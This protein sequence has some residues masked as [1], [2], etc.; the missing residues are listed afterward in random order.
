MKY[1]SICSGIE[2]ATVAWHGFGWTPLAFSE[3]EA[4]PSAVLAARWPQVPNLGDMTKFAEWPEEI[5]AECDLLVGGPP[6][7][8][9][10]VAG[11][12]KSL[13]D[14]RGNITLAYV[15]LLNHI[16]EVRKRHGRPPA[17]ALY[18]NV[19]G[20]LS[21]KDNAF[22]CLIGAL[23]GCDEAPETETGKW[24]KAGYVCGET[25][26]V[27]Y[28]I[29]D[30]QFFGVAQRRRR[31][32]LV[33]V[34]SELVASLGDNACPSEILSLRESVRGN[35][36]SRSKAWEGAARS[37]AASLTSSGRGVER[38]G[39][40]THALTT[41]AACEEDGTGIGNPIVPAHAVGFNWQNGGG[42][43]KANDGLGITEEGTGPL[44]RCNT[45]AVAFTQNQREEVRILDVA[46]ACSAEP[47]SHQQTYIAQQAVAFSDSAAANSHGIAYMVEG[48]PP[49]RG[50]QG[51]NVIPAVAYV[52]ATNLHSKEEAPRYEEAAVSACLNGWDERHDP[53]KH[54]VAVAFKP[55]QSE[56]AGGTFVTEEFAP[57]MQGQNNGSTAVP[58]VAFA[59]R[60]RDG[61]KVP[62]I[63]KDGV[64]P[65]LTNPGGG[66][67]SDAV[68]VCLP[69]PLQEVSK[70]TGKS[71]DDPRAGIG[72]GSAGD[73][74][75]TLQA[76]AQHGCHASMQ[77][78]RLTPAECEFLQGFPAG[79]TDIIF[80]KKPAADGPRYRALGNS[81]A[82]PCMF[83]LGHRIQEATK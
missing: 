15:R 55:G 29:L 57:T 6:C 60:T 44:Q 80:R 19:P 56:A 66:G 47:G 82:V 61:I 22:G 34:P 64:V 26:R 13:D 24:P 73:P 16:D 23:A 1:I 65:A 14:D 32:F 71:T 52:K 83:W 27:G 78:R 46:S 18:E 9:F 77:V 70:R 79:H 36:P 4:F 10:S 42:Y 54:M 21:T 45:P 68:N 33:A 43:G 11:L 72:I 62:E 48:T 7:Q 63:M 31:I 40:R 37:T 76:G 74:M 25:R 39:Q 81:M 69:T 75:Y 28:R 41:R 35:P 17:I 5:L 3:I 53:P 30:A 58:A 38:P 8:A 20:L 2:A 59:N 67:R 12:R 49:L 51:G 50:G